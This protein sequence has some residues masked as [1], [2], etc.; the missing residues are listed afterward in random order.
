MTDMDSTA[1][2]AFGRN[3]SAIREAKGMTQEEVAKRAGLDQA[4]LSHFE[5]GAR[6]PSL[7]NLIKL[8][9]ALKCPIDDMV[10]PMING[11]SL[12]EPTSDR[13]I[14]ALERIADALEEQPTLR[15]QMAMASLQG[16]LSTFAHPNSP[17]TA[18]KEQPLIDDSVWLADEIIRATRQ[19]EGKD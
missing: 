4:H 18:G 17:G 2:G 13:L 11:Q 6:K 9:M 14:A 19:K 7:E 1:G 8:S 5:R 3:I 15:D 10:S 12:P 16:L